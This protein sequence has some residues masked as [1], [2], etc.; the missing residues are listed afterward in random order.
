[1]PP[2][3]F[4]PMVH[5]HS[6]YSSHPNLPRV[7]ST[8]HKNLKQSLFLSPTVALN[9]SCQCTGTHCPAVLL[10]KMPVSY[11]MTLQKSNLALVGEGCGMRLLAYHPLSSYSHQQRYPL[12][13]GLLYDALSSHQNWLPI[14][15]H[16]GKSKF[17][18]KDLKIIKPRK[19]ICI[20]CPR[21]NASLLGLRCNKGTERDICW[22]HFLSNML[23]FSFF[24]KSCCKAHS[25]SCWSSVMGQRQYWPDLSA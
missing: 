24:L 22:L 13:Q 19:M 3:S 11:A 6:L 4:I 23:T 18:Q 9:S 20:L 25:L 8:W 2:F 7:L 1:M 14:T 5:G 12:R 16:N 21:T 10:P 17:N 15:S